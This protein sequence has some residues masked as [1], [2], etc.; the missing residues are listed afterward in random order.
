MANLRDSFICCDCDD[1][2][3]LSDAVRNA[4]SIQCP[5]CASAAVAPLSCWVMPMSGVIDGIDAMGL[6]RDL[7][8]ERLEAVNAH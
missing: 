8:A 3:S 2:F 1:V 4:E 5:A 7:D 6:R